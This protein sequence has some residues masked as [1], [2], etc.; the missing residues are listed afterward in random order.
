V[1][2]RILTPRYASP[3]QMRGASLT[4]ASDVY[5]LGVI[6]Y[7]LLTGRSPYIGVANAAELGT[8]ISASTSLPCCL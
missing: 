7:E 5:S 8:G 2:R 3:E 1:C 4:T 6:L